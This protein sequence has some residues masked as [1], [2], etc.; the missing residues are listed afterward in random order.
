[1]AH[2]RTSRVCTNDVLYAATAAPYP[3]DSMSVLEIY[4]TMGQITGYAVSVRTATG[5][6][7]QNRYWYES[8][9]GNVSDGQGLAVCTSCHFRATNDYTY[10]K[11]P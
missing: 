8:N 10:L 7:G 9:A 1:V 6:G 11:V 4:G 3:T 5:D 2:S